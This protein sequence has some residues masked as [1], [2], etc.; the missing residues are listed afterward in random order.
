M[1]ERQGTPL[2]GR[3]LHGARNAPDIRPRRRAFERQCLDVAVP[4]TEESVQDGCDPGH[5]ML[6][7]IPLADA[8]KIDTPNGN[9]AAAK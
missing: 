8:L 1:V 6:A 7:V 4:V 9:A 3:S 5:A 2:A